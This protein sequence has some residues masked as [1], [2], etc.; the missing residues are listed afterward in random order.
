M[1][2]SQ[3]KSDKFHDRA[4]DSHSEARKLVTGLAVGSLGV[5]YAT[6]TG[7]DPPVLDASSKFLVFWIIVLMGVST[8]SGLVA[9]WAGAR[10][11]Y[12]VASAYEKEPNRTT[13]PDVPPHGLK[14]LCDF[15]LV[16]AFGIGIALALVFVLRLTSLT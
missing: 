7:K 9:W 8:L 1:S 12:N 2:N 16:V 3:S 6:L 15:I 5:F 10:W 14:K 4:G 13:F 11:S